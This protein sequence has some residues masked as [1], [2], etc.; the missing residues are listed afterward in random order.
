MLA[1]A[2]SLCQLRDLDVSACESMTEAGGLAV[3]NERTTLSTL[4]VSAV[5]AVTDSCVLALARCNTTLTKLNVS[6][7]QR[8][9]ARYGH[10]GSA[11]AH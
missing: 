1:L 7:C 5:P 2:T 8:V 9:R 11:S 3:I 10:G 4:N 6:K